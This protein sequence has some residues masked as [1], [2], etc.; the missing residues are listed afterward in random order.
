MIKEIKLILA[1]LYWAVLIGWLLPM[2][3][4]AAHTELVILGFILLIVSAYVTYRCTLSAIRTKK[5]KKSDA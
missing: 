4:S 1:V 2:L 3:I 5:E